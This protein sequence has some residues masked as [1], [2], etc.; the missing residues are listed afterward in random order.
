VDETLFELNWNHRAR[1]PGVRQF[2][3]YDHVDWI[4]GDGRHLDSWALTSVASGTHWVI[5]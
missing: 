3:L 5:S 1:V 2:D 4:C